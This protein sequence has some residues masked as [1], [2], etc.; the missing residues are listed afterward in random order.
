MVSGKRRKH[1]ALSLESSGS[2]FVLLIQF[3]PS[4]NNE[5]TRQRKK[6]REQYTRAFDEVTFL[7][8]RNL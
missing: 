3:A 4:K 5:D 1:T 8:M 6:M 7:K 2:W